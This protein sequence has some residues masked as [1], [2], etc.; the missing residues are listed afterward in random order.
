M[1][2]PGRG[3]GVLFAMT[4][5]DRRTLLA[6]GAL[7]IASAGCG[8]I[9]AASR[10]R[11]GRVV[12]V[13]AGL[14][15]LVVAHELAKRGR[16]VVV[17]EAQARV[18][19]RIRTERGFRD[20]LYVEAGA[21]HVIGDNVYALL[22]ELGV[23][24]TMSVR[25]QGA[26]VGYAG[27]A[28]RVIPAGEQPPP[29]GY[30]DDELALGAT[31]LRRRYLEIIDRIDPD[32]V[33]WPSELA[34]VDRVSMAD[35]L[36][37]RGASPGFLAAI[38]AMVPLGVG[39]DT[40]S[41]LAVLREL[42]A[43]EREIAAAAS[44]APGARRGNRILG[45][46]DQLPRALAARLGDRVALSTAVARVE[47][48]PDG[49]TVI[50]VT[51]R[52]TIRVDAAAVVLTMPFAVLREIGIAPVWSARKARAIA[53]LDMSPVTRVWLECDAP[54]WTADGLSGRAET[55]LAS[56]TIRPDTDAPTAAAGAV[57]GVYAWQDRARHLAAR[58]PAD[59]VATL[60][61]D[62]ERVFPGARRH[63]IG[64]TSIAWEREPFARG[65]YAWFK[66]GQLTE[67]FGAAIAPEGVF[68]FA[69]DGA[70]TRPGWMRGAI[71]SAH[72]VLDE[73]LAPV[74]S[75]ES[76]VPAT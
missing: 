12:V 54:F 61:D 68:H 15:G 52:G 71:A 67:A 26:L 65:G 57:L 49:A 58:A 42:A 20:G 40:V 25:S 74:P 64:G 17:L 16:D 66:P 63:A 45:G 5:L 3:I 55:D 22:D 29:A 30:R 8:G 7:W 14:A 56:G 31:G 33:H 9:R 28:R 47:H 18:G 73:L 72:R 43:I 11:A 41:A 53:A 1:M 75:R 37:A 2:Q 24:T 70:S 21:T 38:N 13:G 51:P 4:G 69:G 59:R 36:G 32:T 76:S 39:L 27:G 23:A 62:C 10:P 34:A 46:S 48:G 35:W 60:R 6:A 44:R 19:G 50:A